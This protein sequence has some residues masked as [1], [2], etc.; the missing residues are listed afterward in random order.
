MI[1]SSRLAKPGFQK[2]TRQQPVATYQLTNMRQRDGNALWGVGDLHV[3]GP[4]S[5]FSRQH[6][7]G[8]CEFAACS[9]AAAQYRRPTRHHDVR[10][11]QVHHFSPPAGEWVAAGTGYGWWQGF[12]L[13]CSERNFNKSRGSDLAHGAL[14]LIAELLDRVRAT[15]F[16]AEASTQ[17]QPIEGRIVQV[18]HG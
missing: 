17:A 6:G 2:P 11:P 14:E 12:T 16:D 3:S 4:F 10:A 5:L 9:G 7:H 8:Q 13:P 1:P 15:G 18:E